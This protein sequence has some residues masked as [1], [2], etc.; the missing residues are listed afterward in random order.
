MA[1]EVA[2]DRREAAGVPGDIDRRA[3]ARS[4]MECPAE[5]L[6]RDRRKGPC[7]GDDEAGEDPSKQPAGRA[8]LDGSTS[9]MKFGCGS[10]CL[11]VGA[12]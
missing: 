7:W 4:S 8:N 1:A 6:A 5:R 12:D 2:V 11:R 10:V 3:V 9:C